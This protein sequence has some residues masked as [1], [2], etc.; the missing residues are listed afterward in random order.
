MKDSQ[1]ISKKH[2]TWPQIEN[3]LQKRCIRR[4]TQ[5]LKFVR[6]VR[7]NLVGSVRGVWLSGERRSANGIP[8]R[9]LTRETRVHQL[10]ALTLCSCGA[11]WVSPETVSQVMTPDGL[12]TGVSSTAVPGN[13]RHMFTT[14]A[15]RCQGL[16]TNRAAAVNGSGPGAQHCPR[17]ASSLLGYEPDKQLPV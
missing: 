15:S 4:L 7:Q 12:L 14:M 1:F 8:R 11:C 5:R 10:R 6:N 16:Y 9:A 17:L 13:G 3:L 2:L